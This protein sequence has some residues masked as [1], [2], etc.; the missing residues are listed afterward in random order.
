MWKYVL[1]RPMVSE[2]G[3]EWYYNS[4]GVELLAGIL[5]HATGHGIIDFAREFL[6]EPIGIESF[7][8]W[9][10]PASEQYGASGGLYL[11]P[12]DMARFGYLFL[13]NGTWSGTQIIS[14]DWV[15]RSTEVY[16]STG[17]YD[18]GYLWW[19]IPDTGVYEATGHYEQ[20]IYVIPEDDI[21]VVFT[22][23]VADEAYHPTD[24]FVM[25]Y[26]IPSLTPMSSN[27]IFPIVFYGA[28]IVLPL[29]LV[30]WKYRVLLGQMN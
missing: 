26:V 17:W 6:F 28:I 9:R 14:S 22:G 8:W 18:Y 7:S 29:I 5:E 25:D 11:T 30:Y 3:K 21:V 4:G 12:R 1:D 27:I 15:Q 2:P 19:M 24:Y 10:V 16:Y 23:N 20:K 13:N